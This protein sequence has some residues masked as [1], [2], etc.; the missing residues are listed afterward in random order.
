M[1]GGAALRGGL[2]LVGGLHVDGAAPSTIRGGA[3]V[4]NGDSLGG[5]KREGF[6]PHAET[7]VLGSF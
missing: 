5:M 7:L 6:H 3:R 2:Q 1:E 4:L